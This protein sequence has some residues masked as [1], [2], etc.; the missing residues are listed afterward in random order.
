MKGGRWTDREAGRKSR[1]TGR[2]DRQTVW[3]QKKSI[4]LNL[5]SETEMR[6]SARELHENSKY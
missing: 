4:D 3:P 2:E 1:E 5:E 6:D